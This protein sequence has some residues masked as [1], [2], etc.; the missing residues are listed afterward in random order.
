[1]IDGLLCRCREMKPVVVSLFNKQ[2]RDRLYCQ[3][4]SDYSTLC[5]ICGRTLPSCKAVFGHMMRGHPK[6]RVFSTDLRRKKKK[7][8]SRIYRDRLV[9]KNPPPLNP[10]TETLQE[11]H[12]DPTGVTIYINTWHGGDFLIQRQEVKFFTS[13]TATLWRQCLSEMPWTTTSCKM[14]INIRI[15]LKT[16]SFC[17]RWCLWFTE[18]SWVYIDARKLHSISLFL[19]DNFA[20]KTFPEFS[21]IFAMNDFSY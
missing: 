3:V 18:A 7:V 13:W 9:A 19:L 5:S 11:R 17:L 16:K 20:I 10:E 6:Q 8:S 14:L 12:K 15:K 4:L 21:H 1:M 2:E